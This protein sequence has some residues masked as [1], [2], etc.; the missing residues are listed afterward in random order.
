MPKLPVLK[1]HE[2]VTRL[3]AVGSWESSTAGPT[4]HS[5]P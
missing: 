1:P 5:P 2:V 3:E 4:S